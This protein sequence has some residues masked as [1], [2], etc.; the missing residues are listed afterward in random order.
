MTDILAVL[1][2]AGILAGGVGA[3]FLIG[4]MIEMD[5]ADS[6]DEAKTMLTTGLGLLGLAATL[7]LGVL[8]FFR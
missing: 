3:A 6:G 7:I 8:S 5:K 2:F 1:F 4:G